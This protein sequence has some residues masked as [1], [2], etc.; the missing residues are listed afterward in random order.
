MDKKIK[1]YLSNCFKKNDIYRKSG[2]AALSSDWL[3]SLP[4]EAVS[5]IQQYSD[6]ESNLNRIYSQ[7]NWSEFYQ[8]GES[9]VNSPVARIC[10]IE[11]EISGKPDVKRLVYDGLLDMSIAKIRLTS[12]TF[13][14]SC[15]GFACINSD[16]TCRLGSEK[17]RSYVDIVFNTLGIFEGRQSITDSHFQML[18]S[19][20]R[21]I[22]DIGFRPRIYMFSLPFSG[23]GWPK[24]DRTLYYGAEHAKIISN[25]FYDIDEITILRPEINYL[26]F[27]ANVNWGRVAKNAYWSFIRRPIHNV[28]AEIDFCCI[29]GTFL[30]TLPRLSS[31]K[32]ILLAACSNNRFF[33]VPSDIHTIMCS[34]PDNTIASKRVVDK[35]L[36]FY[37]VTSKKLQL[38]SINLPK[39]AQS[40]SRTTCIICSNYL[41]LAMLKMI[42]NREIYRPLNQS[43]SIIIGHASEHTRLMCNRIFHS[44]QFTGFCIDL[45]AIYKSISEQV[46]RPFTIIPFGMY[47]MATSVT[48]SAHKDIPLLADKACDAN[49]YIPGDHMAADV[50]SYASKLNALSRP[51]SYDIM[52]SSMKDALQVITNEIMQKQRRNFF[53]LIV[54]P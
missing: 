53:D 43:N 49:S 22:Q 19:L 36:P 35:C 40:S 5:S 18:Y 47:G 6:Y 1:T 20:C 17:Y 51:S 3:S 21:T 25:L 30:T 52:A 39:F 23:M 4:E 48:L 44:C 37:P 45:P 41:D 46:Q 10:E 28:I 14:S 50:T 7:A 32:R 11:L 27:D 33:T 38:N 2:L 24:G 29:S 34:N 54:N 15:H 42:E 12:N 26:E 13:I 31:P 8:L 9:M 16:S